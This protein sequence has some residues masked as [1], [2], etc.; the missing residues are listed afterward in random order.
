MKEFTKMDEQKAVE[1]SEEVGAVSNDIIDFLQASGVSMPVGVFAA[2]MAFASGA[3]V[4][5]MSLP[6][7]IE[8]VRIFY[9]RDLENYEADK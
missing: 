9:K 4:L 5:S 6:Q 2:G 8:L 1:I 7:T 3:G